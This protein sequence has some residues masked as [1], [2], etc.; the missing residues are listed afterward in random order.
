L[1]LSWFVGGVIVGIV[2]V[3]VG[4]AVA[5]VIVGVVSQWALGQ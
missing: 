4:I 1:L 2:G 3:I 5:G